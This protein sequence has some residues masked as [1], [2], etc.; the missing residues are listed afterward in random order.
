V[1]VLDAAEAATGVRPDDIPSMTW[2]EA[3]DRYGNDKPD[4]RFEMLL[5]DLSDVFA[6]TQVKAFSGAHGE[7]DARARWREISRELA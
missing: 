1:A 6:T 3:L 5:H 2:A 7:G 4:M